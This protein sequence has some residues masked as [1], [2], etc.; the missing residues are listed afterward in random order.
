MM[1]YSLQTMTALIG[2]RSSQT[3]VR[4]AH[5]RRTMTVVRAGPGAISVSDSCACRI[6]LPPTAIWPGWHKALGCAQQGYQQISGD[7][8][9]RDSSAAG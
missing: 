7:R 8:D 2:K 6:R 3:L 1:L 4:R 9:D 5:P